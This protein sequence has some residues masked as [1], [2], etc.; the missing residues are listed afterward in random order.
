MTEVRCTNTSR[1]ASFAISFVIAG[2]TLG[3]DYK[4]P[5]VDSPKAFRYEAKEVADTANTEWWKQFQDP[6]LDKLVADALANNKNVKIA[7]ANVANAAGV[8]TTTR[9]ALFPQIGYQADGV[10]ARQS[11][12]NAAPFPASV[13]NPA[14][15]Y[16]ALATACGPFLPDL[17]LRARSATSF[18]S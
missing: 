16:Q 1:M 2:C 8:L 11:Q 13:A 17:Q 3:P 4:R 5:A 18:E 15:Q 9:S 12:S 7:A 10:R 6:V 14:D